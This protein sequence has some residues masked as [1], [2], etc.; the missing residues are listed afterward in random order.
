MQGAEHF[1][2]RGTRGIV[3]SG[4]PVEIREAWKYQIQ[5]G[6]FAE[7]KET[8]TIELIEIWPLETA[9]QGLIADIMTGE[10]RPDI[11][12]DRI[13]Y[14]LGDDGLPMPEEARVQFRAVDLANKQALL[15]IPVH[16]IIGTTPADWRMRTL[17]SDEITKRREWER[18]LLR[19]DNLKAFIET[20]KPL[21]NL[22]WGSLDFAPI[23]SRLRLRQRRAS[24]ANEVDFVRKYTMAISRAET[25]LMTI[26][27]L[28][29]A[30][31]DG[32]MDRAE[33][34]W[35]HLSETIPAEWADAEYNPDAVLDF[36]DLK[37]TAYQLSKPGQPD[38]CGTPDASEPR[39]VKRRGRP[40]KSAGATDGATE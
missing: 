5:P 35:E 3:V 21:L 26:R 9:S 37:R 8:V 31:V 14:P 20:F 39:P 25:D 12:S 13:L 2:D 29:L 32:D 27:A 23:L 6:V 1:F 7:R 18:T 19:P 10:V 34:L 30:V 33:L 16:G 4:E 17:R 24:K 28:Y 15:H 38:K 11:V 22:N 36:K 40:R